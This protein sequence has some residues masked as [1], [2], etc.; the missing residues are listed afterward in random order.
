M[1]ISLP[2]TITSFHDFSNWLY[3]NLVA[4]TI[5][6]EFSIPNCGIVRGARGLLVW[7]VVTATKI[8]LRCFVKYAKLTSNY[9]SFIIYHT[10]LQAQPHIIKLHMYLHYLLGIQFGPHYF[11]QWASLLAPESSPGG[12]TAGGSSRDRGHSPLHSSHSPP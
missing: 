9:H 5:A 3:N 12:L 2:S 10:S 7:S 8:V 4:V 1:H 11:G 6:T